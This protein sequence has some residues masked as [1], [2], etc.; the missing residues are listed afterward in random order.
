MAEQ[1]SPAAIRYAFEDAQADIVE[2][3]DQLERMKLMLSR[4]AYPRRGTGDEFGDVGMFAS[5]IQA[6]WSMEDLEANAKS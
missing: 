5:E 3:A 2:L 4:I 1:Q 6:T